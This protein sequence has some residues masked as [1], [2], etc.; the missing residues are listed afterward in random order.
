MRDIEVLTSRYYAF[1]YY[2]EE[3]LFLSLFMYLCVYYG[4]WPIK[5]RPKTN[6]SNCRFW[7]KLAFDWLVDNPSQK[8]FG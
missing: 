5:C 1:I 4:L 3:E 8:L 7:K 6:N 2:C